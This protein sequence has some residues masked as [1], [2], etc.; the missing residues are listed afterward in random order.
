MFFNFGCTKTAF[1]KGFWMYKISRFKEDAGGSKKWNL[2]KSA[3]SP[4]KVFEIKEVSRA[5]K[6]LL[7]FPLKKV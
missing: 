1:S 4:E 3:A 2:R 7:R 6:Q 5:E